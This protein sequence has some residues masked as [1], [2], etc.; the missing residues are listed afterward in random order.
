M[1]PLL[2][3][4]PQALVERGRIEGRECATRP[5]RWASTCGSTRPARA[6]GVTIAQSI[7]V[8]ADQVRE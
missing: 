1:E 2:K 8:R 7:L 4:F 3:Q 6:I 5:S